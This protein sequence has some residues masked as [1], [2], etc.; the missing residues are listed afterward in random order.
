[1]NCR[2]MHRQGAAGEYRFEPNEPGGGVWRHSVDGGMKAVAN[3]LPIDEVGSDHELSE[4]LSRSA[5]TTVI[6]SR[7][8]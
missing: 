1:V 2:I 4:R 6:V 8:W 7:R 5:K 3:V